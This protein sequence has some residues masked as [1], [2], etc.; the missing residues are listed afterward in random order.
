MASTP[1]EAAH[2]AAA[3]APH[4]AHVGSAPHDAHV[5]W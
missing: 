5:G 2:V 4:A 3:A 1:G